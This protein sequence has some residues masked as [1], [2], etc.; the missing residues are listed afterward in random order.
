MDA[1]NLS[2]IEALLLK[3]ETLLSRKDFL[4]YCQIWC[5]APVSLCVWLNM[6]ID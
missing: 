1:L 3:L 5:I 2:A 4:S 6:A